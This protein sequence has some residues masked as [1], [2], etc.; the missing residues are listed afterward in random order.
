MFTL[1]MKKLFITI[2]FLI[3]IS[4][5]FGQTSFEE[6][7]S[8][9]GINHTFNASIPGIGVSFCDFNQDGLDDLTLATADDEPLQFYINQGGNFEAVEFDFDFPHEDHAKQVLWVDYD[10]DGDKDLYVS[11]FGGLDQL[12]RNDGDFQFTNVTFTA[13]LSY[14]YERTFG[15]CWAD[16]NRDGWLDLYYSERIFPQGGTPN[17]NRLFQNNADGTF[18][19][20]TNETNVADEGKIPFCAAFLDYN[21]DKWPDIYIANDKGSI[22]TLLKNNGNG[23]FS[24]VGEAANANIMM[25]AMC[26]AVGDYDNDGWQDI[27]I[28]NIETGNVLLHNLGSVNGEDPVFEEVANATGTAFYSIGWGANFLDANNDGWQDLY[29]SGS[30]LGSVNTSSAYYENLGNGT[31]DEPMAGFEGDTVISFSNA[32]G[33]FNSDGYPDIMVTNQAPYQSQLWENT[34]GNGNWLKVSLEGV[35]SNKDGIGSKI[36]VKVDNQSYMRYTHCG[37]GFLGQNSET[38]LFGLHEY[39]MVDTV[40]VTWPTGHVDILTNLSVNETHHIIEGMSTNG[41]IE[42]DPD[43]S[44]LVN[45]NEIVEASNN[46]SIFPNPATDQISLNTDSEY[47]NYIILGIQGNIIKQ[48]LLN[49]NI[50]PIQS[51][52]NGFY[53]LMLIDDK[54]NK[55]VLKFEKL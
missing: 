10:N 26:V 27:Y 20:V 13:T 30:E 12:F 31:F 8:Q 3:W 1:S 46:L 17:K 2:L 53:L 9:K 47:A 35:L 11:T 33:D 14:D 25:D 18:T 38:E 40:K 48:G 51:L 24:D 37:I 4:T 22:N 28:T 54:G 15:A 7:A 50:I 42:V 39:E 19:E 6:V 21:N 16:F 32:I 49:E 34:G 44:L 29:V 55:N 52:N 5:C 45:T 43:I 41:I 36:E 23:T